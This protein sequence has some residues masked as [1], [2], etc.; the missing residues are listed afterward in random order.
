MPSTKSD[1]DKEIGQI[2]RTLRTTAGISQE[3]LGEELGITFQQIQK[4]EK[5][6][7]RLSVSSFI[8]ICKVIGVT[9]NDVLGQY[10]P[11]V[12]NG[13]ETSR[14]ADQV[15]KMKRKMADIKSAV[16]EATR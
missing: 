16:M 10:F 11:D 5:G 14:L 3:K 12:P 9:P 1:T 8:T 6:L 13:G 7:N 2:I 15:A 4:Y